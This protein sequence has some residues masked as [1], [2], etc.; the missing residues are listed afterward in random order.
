LPNLGLLIIKRGGDFGGCR[1][2]H[3]LFHSAFNCSAIVRVI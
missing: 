2:G 3:L 1:A